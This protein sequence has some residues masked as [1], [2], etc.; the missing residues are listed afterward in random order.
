MFTGAP[1]PNELSIDGN[2]FSI[3]PTP[4]YPFE[5]QMHISAAFENVNV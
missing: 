5:L 3:T 2:N 1:H 4:P